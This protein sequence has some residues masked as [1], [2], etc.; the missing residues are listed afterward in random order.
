LSA[1][2]KD[3]AVLVSVLAGTAVGG[4]YCASRQGG[5]VITDG[6]AASGVYAVLVFLGTLVLRKGGTEGALTV[7]ILIAAV[8]GGCFGG[9]LKLNRKKQKRRLKR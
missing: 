4:V 9:V 6:L 7:R 2:L 5:G 8:A 3:V 1:S